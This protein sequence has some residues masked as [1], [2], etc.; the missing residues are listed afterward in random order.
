MEIGIGVSPTFGQPDGFSPVDTPGLIL[1]LDADDASTITDAGS[2]KVSVWADKSGHAANGTQGTDANRPVTG[3][4]MNGRNALAFN[5]TD[6]TFLQLTDDGSLTS[7]DYTIFVV[8]SV[9][10]DAF[11]DGIMGSQAGGGIDHRITAGELVTMGKGGGGVTL[12]TTTALGLTP[13]VVTTT[14]GTAGGE[15]WV[16][17]VS[18]DTDVTDIGFVDP[19]LRIG[20]SGAQYLEGSVGEIRIYDNI[21]GAAAIAAHHTDL[22]NKWVP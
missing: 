16:N 3:A 5:R 18:E 11:I 9:T 17:G 8:L 12:T 20:R 2:G 22:V 10:A 1:W 15:I 14:I 19:V 13:A 4:T 21:L 7:T 6:A